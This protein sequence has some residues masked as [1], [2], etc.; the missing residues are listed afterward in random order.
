MKNY[1]I[2]YIANGN[3]AED[4]RGQVD[5]AIDSK[6]TELAGTV[7]HASAA[8]RRRLAYEIDKKTSGFLRSLQIQ[9]DPEHI[10]TIETMLRKDNNIIRFTILATSRREEVASELIEKYV[11]KKGD[12]KKAGKPTIKPRAKAVEP[13]APVTMEDVEKGIEEALTEEVK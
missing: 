7:E 4:E 1:E 9:L 13:A 5:A 11:P 10:K 3:L 8:L 12:K 6:I 2:T